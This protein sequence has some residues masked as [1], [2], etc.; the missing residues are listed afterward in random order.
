MFVTMDA[1]QY[2]ALDADAFEARRSEVLAELDN[3]ES[4]VPFD[5]LDAE[6]AIIQREAQRRIAAAQLR[7][8]TAQAVATGAGA[9]MASSK[10]PASQSRQGFQVV[11]S[12]DPYDTPQYRDAFMSLVQTGRETRADSI[13]LTTDAPVMIPTTLS[14]RIIEEMSEYGVIYPEVNVIS[15]QGG[16]DIPLL[17]LNLEASWVGETEVS[18]WQKLAA[19]DKISFTFH[20]L[21]CR[22]MISF[23]AAATTFDEFKNRFAPKTAEAMARAMDQAVINGD[24]NGKPLGILN[25]TRVNTQVVELTAEDMADWKTWHSKVIKILPK[26]YRDGKFYMAQSTWDENL[27]TLADNENAPIIDG[28]NPHT[29]DYETRLVGKQVKTTEDDI[30]PAFSS[31]SAGDVFGMFANLQR[32]YTVNMQPGEPLTTVRYPDYDKRQHKL[33]SYLACDGRVTEPWGLLLLKK[34]ASA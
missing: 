25:D 8:S 17:S 19:N 4:A 28:Y 24:G 6:V 1:A 10:A 18:E 12:E 2:R 21:E 5:D 13:T 33:V 29:G 31:A 34:K 3:A 27:A 16:V 11:R 23:L 14:H 26:L 32:S 7:A 22:S 15:V 30:F 9:V 20:E